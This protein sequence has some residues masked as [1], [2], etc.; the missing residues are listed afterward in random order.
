MAGWTNRGK[1]R[2]LG[3]YFRAESVPTNLYIALVTS[4]TAPTLSHNTLGELVQ[5]NS[6]NGYSN[7]G[8]QLARNS[9]DFDTLTEDD[10][11]ARSL[12][13]LKDITWTA[14]GG[15]IPASGS[16]AR[17]AVLT[18]DN[19]TVNSRD[20]FAFWDL[21]SDRQVSSGQDLT[22]QNCELRLTE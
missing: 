8:Y 13:Q 12:V 15:T 21:S 10:N 19:A 18:D 1:Y 14:S 7:G 20:L 5:I 17:Y 22:L 3:G 4:G 16:G 6:G 11:N 2:V 9:T